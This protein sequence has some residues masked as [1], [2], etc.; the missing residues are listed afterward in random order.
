MKSSHLASV[1]LAAM[2]PLTAGMTE[3]VHPVTGKVVSSNGTPSP[4]QM[5]PGTSMRFDGVPPALLVETW[6]NQVLLRKAATGAVVG[7]R[8]HAN[9][10]GYG[11]DVHPATRVLVWVGVTGSIGIAMERID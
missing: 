2:S 5:E 7:C 9:G 6:I 4:G 8:D 1:I 11:I 10:G 3:V